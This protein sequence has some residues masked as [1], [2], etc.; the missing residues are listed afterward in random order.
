[1]RVCPQM[2]TEQRH[3]NS[4]DRCKVG[5]RT[6]EGWDRA[7]GSRQQ[8]FRRRR[9]VPEAPEGFQVGLIQHGG[10]CAC[11]ETFQAWSLSGFANRQ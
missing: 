2:L 8:F 3:K 4:G 9:G 6:M 10:T 11:V 5:G 1:M 7:P